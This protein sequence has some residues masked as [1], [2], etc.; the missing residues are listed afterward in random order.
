M[1][2]FSSSIGR[3]FVMAVTG[4][5]L[6]L[7]VT[8]HV[9]MNSVALLWPTAYNAVCEFLGANWYALVASVGLAALFV[10]H[11][12]YALWLTLQNRRARGNDRYAVTS[13]PAQVEWSS[14]N[15]LVL[16]FVVIAFLLLHLWQ[17]WA[18]MQLAEIVPSQIAGVTTVDFAGAPANPAMG[19]MFLQ[20]AFSNFWAPVCY[21]VAF[22]ALWLH[23]THGFWSMFH[24]AGWD[25]NTWLPRL[26]CIS[27][28][29]TSIVIALFV[30]QIFVFTYR[31]HTNY[32]AENE[33][34]QAQY[35]EAW[36]K[37]AKALS[38]EFE[39]GLLELIAPQ[40]AVMNNEASSPEARMTASREAGEIQS[41]YIQE[42]G[43]AFLKK[44]EA[45]QNAFTA[46]CP[47]AAPGQE[48][49]TLS[50]MVNAVR[51][52]LPKQVPAELIQSQQ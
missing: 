14:K 10:I 31:A 49:Q 24:T 1:W 27:N 20:V 26:K 9:L 41:K 46:Q 44:A 8:F 28:W 42:N 45:V 6:V 36:S 12:L 34:L 11:I 38:T 22:A 33:A 30:C 3:K 15:M 39:A 35:A 4:L 13:R 16:G 50:Q 17:F 29:W 32:Y 52:M 43:E 2:L 25:N 21:L 48:M 40:V 37:E 51:S 23:M 47:K 7:F 19:T 18:K 5:C